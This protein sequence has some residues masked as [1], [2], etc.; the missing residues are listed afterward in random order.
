MYKQVFS[1]CRKS[2][3][4]FGFVL[5]VPSRILYSQEKNGFFELCLR[6][7]IKESLDKYLLHIVYIIL[8]HVYTKCIIAFIT[9][10]TERQVNGYAPGLILSNINSGNEL[11]FGVVVLVSDPC[12]ARCNGECAMEL[13]ELSLSLDSSRFHHRSS[14][15]RSREKSPSLHP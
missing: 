2:F 6:A 5:V 12:Q 4:F 1:R 11:G 15:E 8:Y 3:H 9:S 7:R 13:F 14:R 10:V